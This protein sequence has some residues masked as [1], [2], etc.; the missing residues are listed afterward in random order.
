MAEDQRERLRG[1]LVEVA[2]SGRTATYAQAASNVGLD[3]RRGADHNALQQML[4]GISEAEHKDSRPLLS[5]VCVM[6]GVKRPGQGF[7]DLARLLGLL[8][9]TEDQRGFYDAELARVHAHWR[10]SQGS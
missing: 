7:F 3:I 9:P 4:R 10:D 8:Q 2:R 6:A 1:F 5:A